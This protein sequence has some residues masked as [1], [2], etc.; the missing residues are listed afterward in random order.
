VRETSSPEPLKAADV[1][2]SVGVQ[3]A[4][5]EALSSLSMRAL[6]MPEFR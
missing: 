6:E 4:S 5:T 3:P 1:G 2:S